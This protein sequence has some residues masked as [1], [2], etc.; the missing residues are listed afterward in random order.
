MDRMC[1]RL[2]SR[3]K[4][5]EERAFQESRSVLADVFGL[6]MAIGGDFGFDYE[7]HTLKLQ[8]FARG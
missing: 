8:T 1:T 5:R 4:L 7:F 3:D 6:Q 2:M